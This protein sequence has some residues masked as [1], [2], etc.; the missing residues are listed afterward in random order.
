MTR[1]RHLLSRLGIKGQGH[2]L[3]VKPCKHDT[4]WTIS[5]RTIKF[6][7]HTSTTYDKRTTPIDFQGQGSKVKVAC[8]TLLLNRVNIRLEPSNLM[9]ILRMTKGRH[10]LLLTAGVK[11]QGH[12]LYLVVKPC[13]HDTDWT[14]SARTVK[15]VMHTFYVKRTTPIVFKVRGQGHMLYLVVKL[16]KHDTDWTVSARTIELG[17]HTP[18]DKRMTSIDFQGQGS[19]VKVI[20]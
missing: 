8:Y 6:C 3:H 4:D 9:H 17:T 2:K 5:A 10:L 20:G 7:T 15:L 19:K 1:G 12:T 16:C 18:Y 11:G 14:V 13:K